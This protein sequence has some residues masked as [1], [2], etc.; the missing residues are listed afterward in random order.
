MLDPIAFPVIAIYHIAAC[1]GLVGLF[2]GHF[3]S[4][5]GLVWCLALW[6][7]FGLF[8]ITLCYHRLLTHQSFKTPR[9]FKYLLTVLAYMSGQGM[10]KVWV[11]KHLKHHA[12]TDL[13]GD[14]HSPLHP[15]HDLHGF[16]WSHVLWVIFKNPDGTDP[17]LMS[18]HITRDPGMVFL[19]RWFW[20][21]QVLIIPTMFFLGYWYAGGGEDGR[22]LGWSWVIWGVGVRTTWTYFITWSINSFGHTPRFGF[23]TYE[24]DDNSTNV[25]GLGILAFGEGW[26]NNHH[27]DPRSASHGM[28]SGPDLTY[29]VIRLLGLIGLASDI[30]EPNWKML[31]KKEKKPVPKT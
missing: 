21:P 27:A 2:T 24:T 5:S 20:V 31:K 10:A 13:E 1:V 14:P 3:F 19:D 29:W 11:G 28:K 25:R 30:K 9:W 16:G 8:G 7:L 17:S 18:K 4:W 26:H 15:K 6:V 22:A 12:E 23:Q